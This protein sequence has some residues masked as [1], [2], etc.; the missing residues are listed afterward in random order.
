MIAS[1]VNIKARDVIKIKSSGNTQNR[2]L[3]NYR[4]AILVRPTEV[5]IDAG[6][7]K[8]RRAIIKRTLS[9]LCV[10]LTA[11]LLTTVYK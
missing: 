7:T 8:I 4:R 3:Q 10:R 2:T 1:I 6:D 11:K 5:T 9:K